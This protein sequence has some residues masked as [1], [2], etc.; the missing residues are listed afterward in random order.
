MRLVIFGV[1]EQHFVHVGRCV[2]EQLVGA[3]EDDQCDFAIAQ[4]RQFVGLLHHP[5]FALVERHLLNIDF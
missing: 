3:A 5:E 4:H 1:L 2:L